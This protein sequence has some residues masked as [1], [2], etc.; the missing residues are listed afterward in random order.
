V[1]FLEE[2]GPSRFDFFAR[3]DV[4]DVDLSQLSGAVRLPSIKHDLSGR[5]I[6]G[7]SSIAKDGQEI[8]VLD[9]EPQLLPFGL[10]EWRVFIVFVANRVEERHRPQWLMALRTGMLKETLLLMLD[11]S[12][13]IDVSVQ[14]DDVGQERAMTIALE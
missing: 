14:E 11:T 9:S 1:R 8:R 4:N 6:R 2:R 13:G 10:N 3:L 7:G 5:L 12:T